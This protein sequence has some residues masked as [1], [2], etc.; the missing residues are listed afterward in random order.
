MGKPLNE[1]QYTYFKSSMGWNDDDVLDFKTCCGIFA[2]C[3]RLL[4]PEFCPQM[5]DRKCDPCHEVSFPVFF[6]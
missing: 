6:F 1:R 4:A 3:E 2:L 5:P